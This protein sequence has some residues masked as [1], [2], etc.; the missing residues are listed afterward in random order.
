MKYMGSTTMRCKNSLFHLAVFVL[1]FTFPTALMAQQALTQTYTSADGVFTMSYPEGWTAKEDRGLIRFSS[2]RAF[3]QINYRNYGEEETARKVF[4]VG[5]STAYGFSEAEELVIAGYAAIQAQSSDQLHTVINFC[6]GTMALA[7]GYVN[8]GDMPTY[9]PT[10]MAMMQTIRFGKGEPQVCRDT[11]AGLRPIT[12]ANAAQVSQVT[13]FGDKAVPV[14]SVAFNPD[15]SAFAAAGMDGSV[16][17]WSTVTGKELVALTGH[18]DGATSVAFGSGGYNIAVGTGSGQVRLWDAIRGEDSGI[19]QQHNTAV[20]SVALFPSLFVVASGSLDGEVRLWDIASRGNERVL[21]DSD[22]PTPVTSVAYNADG[23]ILAA[24]GGNM[25]RLWDVESG[26]VKASLE[27]KISE[28]TSLSFRPDGAALIYGGVNPT[29]WIWNLADDNHALLEGHE[30]QVSA[31]AYSPDGRIIASGDSGSLRLWDAVTGKNLVSL[32]SPSGEAAKSI[33]ISPTGTLIASGSDSGGVVLWGTAGAGVPE[34]AA[35]EGSSG[36]ST[37]SET[38]V[39]SAST[40][41]ITARGSANL[42]GGPGTNF[43]RAGRLSAGQSAQVDGQAKGADGMTWFRLSNGAWVRT[44]VVNAPDPCG[45]V[46][47]VTPP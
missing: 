43:D 6:G 21:V 45:A 26:S 42:R 38:D 30:G 34:A 32:S 46:P 28:I 35:T 1:L 10:F 5:A 4:D 44:D 16:R 12:L 29:V 41:T 18:R 20:E 25:I 33:S 14:T 17:I 47:V 11:F 27:T 19:M 22:N 24:G 7:I 31:L 40:C 39:T 2:D 23:T 15:G 13:T 3:M 9:K 36:T 8:P 37:T